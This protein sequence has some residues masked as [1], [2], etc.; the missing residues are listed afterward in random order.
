MRHGHRRRRGKRGSREGQERSTRRARDGHERC[1]RGAQE[2]HSWAVGTTVETVFYILTHLGHGWDTGAKG[3]QEMHK[4]GTRGALEGHKRCTRG[5]ALNLP[6]TQK[7][8][9]R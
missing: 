5:A 9:D 6:T 8:F 3:T 1:T 7:R 4:R 2:V